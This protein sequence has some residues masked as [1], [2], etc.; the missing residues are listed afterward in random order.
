MYVERKNRKLEEKRT[1]WRIWTNGIIKKRWKQ[2]ISSCRRW[3][4]SHRYRLSILHIFYLSGPLIPVLDRFSLGKRINPYIFLPKTAAK[5][6]LWADGEINFTEIS[7]FHR[8]VLPLLRF[9]FIVDVWERYYRLYRLNGSV[10][11]I[12]RYIAQLIRKD[13]QSVS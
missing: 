12:K 13:R 10:E 9:F 4:F 7:I 6:D 8:C 3:T 11:R 5:L 2:K 1:P